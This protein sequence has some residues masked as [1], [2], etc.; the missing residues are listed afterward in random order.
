MNSQTPKGKYT[1]IGSYIAPDAHCLK[2]KVGE[3]VSEI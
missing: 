2:N 3:K 1:L